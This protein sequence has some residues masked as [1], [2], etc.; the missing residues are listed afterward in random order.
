MPEV[1]LPTRIR[2]STSGSPQE[3]GEEAGN[4]QR[5]LHPDLPF[6]EAQ[7]W[8]ALLPMLKVLEVRRLPFR[9]DLVTDLMTGKPPPPRS[10]PTCSS[11][12]EDMWRLQDLP[13]NVKDILKAGWRSSTEDCYGRAR[14]A[15]KHYLRSTKVPP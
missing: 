1:G 2:V 14:Q 10:C 11:C 7:M 9:E 8:L 13:G 4:V 12:L 15:F 6:W 5:H 3:S